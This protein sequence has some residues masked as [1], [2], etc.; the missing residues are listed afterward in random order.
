MD[1][2][3]TDWKRRLAALLKERIYAGTTGQ[4]EVNLNIGGV[5][6]AYVIK[7]K[8]KG[9]TIIYEKKEIK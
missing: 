1:K 6:K 9:D 4:I 3:L 2:E 8:V 5:T 7:K